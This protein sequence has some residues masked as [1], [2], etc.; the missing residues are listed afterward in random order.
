MR[1]RYCVLLMW[2]AG[3]AIVWPKT[4]SATTIVP[5]PF[6]QLVL[7]ADF[8]GTVEC[9]QAGGIVAKYKV[10]ESW[11][12]EKPGSS[13]SIR[14]AVNYWEPQFPIA[15]CGQR[16][17]VAA[18]KKDPTRLMTTSGGSVPLWW[19]KVPSDY[20]TPLFQGVT[21]LEAG[22]DKSPEFQK[23]RKAVEGLL[24]LNADGREAVFLKLRIGKYF[25]YYREYGS[26]RDAPEPAKITEFRARS[27]KMTTVDAIVDE[28]LHRAKA[29]PK[30]WG[31]LAWY[32]LLGGGGTQTLERLK[33]LTAAESP[34]KRKELNE[35][36]GAIQKNLRP[37]DDKGANKDRDPNEEGAKEPPTKSYLAELRKNLKAGP[38]SNE[39]GE[40]FD[41][42][43]RHDPAA[44]AE[45]LVAWN[46]PTK[47]EDLLGYELGSYFGWRCGKD[48]QRHFKSLLKAKEPFIRVAAAVYLCFEDSKAGVAALEK[49]TALKG[50]AGVWAALTLARRGRKDAIPRALEV[51]RQLP[52]EKELLG[53]MD[54]VPH[55]NLQKRLFVLLSNSARTSKL[56][57]PSVPEDI[58]KKL[59]YAVSWWKQYRNKVDL[60]DPWMKTL[61]KQ[62]ID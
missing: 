8:V 12:G 10:I 31:P 28:L 36:I 29:D 61:E 30:E 18:F 57:Q 39:F 46:N 27:S 17:F 52:G 43:L 33:K 50:D 5:I 51:F 32:A 14:M 16:F 40:A 56:P 41:C 1:V 37:A 26:G 22:G 55:Y 15:M 58:E 13:V 62:K 23:T 38:E 49:L 59:D 53:R 34:W 35:L 21:S 9:V 25:D 24:A 11:K 7:T 3:V 54:F 60:A 6:E 20:R 47:E 48:R 42:L 45:F 44:V 19:R 2:L 4:V